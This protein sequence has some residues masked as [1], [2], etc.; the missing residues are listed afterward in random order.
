MDRNT[1]NDEPGAWHHVMNRGLSKRSIFERPADYRR[2]IARM[3]S[4]V[5]GGWIEVHAYSLLAN[6]FH[7]LVR[8]P[9]GKLS[10]AMHRIENSYVLWF[11]RCYCRDGP[12]FKGRFRS[13]R[14]ESDL[15]WRTVVRYIDQNPVES[16]LVQ[17]PD[18]YE[19]GSA[20]QY[21]RGSGPL[22]LSREVV[23]DVICGI[24]NKPSYLPEY[25]S[26]V[27]DPAVR[28]W[29]KDVVVKSLHNDG[30]LI[31]SVESLM[32][33]TP[34]QVSEWL[35]RNAALAD[36]SKPG[37]PILSGPT[38]MAEIK[39]RI[40]RYPQMR[41]IYRSHRRIG[42]PF[43]F[44]GLLRTVCGMSLKEV[45]H[46]LNCAISTVGSRVEAHRHLLE[47][48]ES[49][50]QIAGEIVAEALEQDWPDEYDGKTRK[51]IPL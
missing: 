18:L 51:I 15:Y 32:T 44:A 26:L 31:G 17:A 47:S 33:R 46:R 2:F 5:H 21:A 48:D 11:N 29:H 37:M 1:R 39:K 7:L 23:E 27:F 45:S 35:V 12:L 19:Y 20:R 9:L 13:K 28:P 6:H 22:W 34:G 38:T 42:W 43:L 49:Y 3:A 16:G 25:Y 36:G 50:A 24:V 14:I 4:V 8:S 40:G 30:G 41:I 10:H